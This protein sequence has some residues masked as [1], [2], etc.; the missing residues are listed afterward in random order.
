[1]GDLLAGGLLEGLDHLVE[2]LQGEGGAGVPGVHSDHGRLR[3][4]RVIVG[5][6]V[7][8]L[9]QQGRDDAIELGIVVERLGARRLASAAPPPAT[10]R[11]AS[12]EAQD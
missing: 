9:G 6:V 1:L 2:G 11:V 5:Q 4:R 12:G 8:A 10:P 7:G 3:F